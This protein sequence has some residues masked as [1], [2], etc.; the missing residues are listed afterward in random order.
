MATKYST[1]H[2]TL[3]DAVDALSPGDRLVVEVDY[4]ISSRLVMPS[5]PDW[6]IEGDGHV[7]IVQTADDEPIIEFDSDNVHS[8]SLR[9]LT[10]LWEN[11]QPYENKNAVAI[12]FNL[13]SDSVSG[14]YWGHIADCVLSGGVRGIGMEGGEKTPLWATTIERTRLRGFFGHALDLHGGPIGMPENALRDI[15]I[16]QTAMAT[17]SEPAQGRNNKDCPVNLVSGHVTISNLGIEGSTEEI[18]KATNV[19]LIADTIHVEHLSY[20]VSGDDWPKLFWIGGHQAIFK[21]VQLDGVVEIGGSGF[22][23]IV[24]GA[25]D[26]LVSI[27]GLHNGLSGSSPRRIL[28]GSGAH[29]DVSGIRTNGDDLHVGI[30]SKIKKSGWVI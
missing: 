17:P 15:W 16:D 2:A 23:T 29:Y 5:F 11:Q 4:S 25:Q 30:G 7:A 3:Q 28:N 12:R 27:E 20:D 9:D 18:M 8:W 22:C 26:A 6:K 13:A 10:L 24:N 21:N 19:R 1:N 14:F